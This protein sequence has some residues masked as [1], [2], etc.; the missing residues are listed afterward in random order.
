MRKQYYQFYQG[1]NISCHDYYKKY[2]DI[3]MTALCLGSDLGSTHKY[4]ED[5]LKDKAADP[6]KPMMMSS[7]MPLPLHTIGTL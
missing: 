4:I 2:K 7:S 6:D 5:V 1:A 3:V